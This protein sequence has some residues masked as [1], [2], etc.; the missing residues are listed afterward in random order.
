MLKNILNLKGVAILNK[1]QQK[2]IIGGGTCY[3]RSFHESIP[4]NYYAT[5]AG[6]MSISEAQSYASGPD[7][8]NWCCDSC[9]S[10]TWL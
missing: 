7:G 10:A 2:T 9:K 8:G 3:A 6:P 1:T 5:T 4:G